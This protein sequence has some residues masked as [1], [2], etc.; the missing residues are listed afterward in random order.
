MKIMIISCPNCN[1]KFKVKDE[2]I[3][4][5]KTKLK[6]SKCSHIFLYEDEK[7]EEKKELEPTADN[8][9][10]K[11][12]SQQTKIKMSLE[13]KV[14]K[15]KWSSKILLIVI[16][17]TIVAGVLS[18]FLLTDLKS[19]IPY[20][21]TKNEIKQRPQNATNNIDAVK[22]ISLEDIKQYMVE[23][24]KIG[25]ILV[26]EGKAVNNFNKPKELIKIEATLFDDKGNVVEKK[27]LLC[28]NKVS[29]FQLQSWSM[30][31]LEKE[32][33]SKVGVLMN[34]TKIPP[35]GSVDFMVLFY[36]PPQ[37]VH[38]YG[39]KVIEALDVEKK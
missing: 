2:L 35:G 31:Q 10:T 14:I 26:I 27:S 1:T 8:V 21:S 36:N 19:K 6:C 11:D 4:P 25:K 32:L 39:V 33:N 29:L 38:E 7:E 15:G 16:P 3:T 28:G 12:T 23:N 5:G 20:I 17:I 22:Y 24:D 18:L 13:E 34:N 9:D 37:N 30:E